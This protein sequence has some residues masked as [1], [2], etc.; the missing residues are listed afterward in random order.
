MKYIDFHGTPLAQIALGCDHWG[1]N[2]PEAIARKQ[3]DIY[4]EMG[5]NQIG[6]AHV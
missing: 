2:I 1:T 6:R 3:L 5:G 4:T